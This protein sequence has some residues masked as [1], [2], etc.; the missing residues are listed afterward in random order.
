MLELPVPIASREVLVVLGRVYEEPRPVSVAVPL[1]IPLF[2]GRAVPAS[3]VPTTLRIILF[4]RVE[5]VPLSP[6]AEGRRVV[7]VPDTALPGRP[8]AVP[9]TA[10]PGRP[11]VVPETELPGRRLPVAEPDAAGRRSPI[12]IRLA[13]GR[14][15]AL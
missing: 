1:T 6:V 15:V 4:S 10:L 5:T 13:L 8:V 3:L 2:E 9:E 7:A 11:V 12:F 14:R